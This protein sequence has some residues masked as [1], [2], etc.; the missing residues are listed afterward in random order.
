MVSHRFAKATLERACGF[1][2]HPLRQYLI[3]MRI[4]LFGGTFDP[5][6]I[7]HLLIVDR[8]IE[9]LKLDR[10][11]IS[12]AAINPLKQLEDPP[13]PGEHRVMMALKAIGDLRNTEVSEFEIQRGGLSYT[14]DF[15]ESIRKPDDDIFLILG[16]DAYNSLD[17]WHRI[18]DLAFLTSFAVAK[19]PG[20][21]INSNQYEKIAIPV[22]DIN[23]SATEIRNRV[24]NGLSIRY[25]VPRDV[26]DHIREYGLYK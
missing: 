21:I 24:K 11:L 13:A 12:P 14:Y 7:G 23:L 10:L 5:I 6:H 2:P 20:C 9:T 16:T 4:G 3:D 26:E 25:M 18:H 1:E 17:R 22:P 15:V 19:R 8:A